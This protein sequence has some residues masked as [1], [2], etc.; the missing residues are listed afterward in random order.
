[1]AIGSKNHQTEASRVEFARKPGMF[2]VLRHDASRTLHD[3]SVPAGATSV[4]LPDTVQC[5]NKSMSFHLEKKV[6][7]SS[8]I[9]ESVGGTDP[10]EQTSAMS[11]VSK[12]MDSPSRK[13]SLQSWIT[14]IC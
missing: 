4:P 7:A 10:K 5:Y 11:L 13:W 12:F 14:K 6:G 2:R 3:A 9:L 1:M 8:F